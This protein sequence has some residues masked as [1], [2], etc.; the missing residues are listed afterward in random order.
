MLLEDR[1]EL[2]YTYVLRSMSLPYGIYSAGVPYLGTS[3]ILGIC[4]VSALGIHIRVS[5]AKAH[6]ISRQDC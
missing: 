6:S 4:D 3:N 5:W 2:D 1:L